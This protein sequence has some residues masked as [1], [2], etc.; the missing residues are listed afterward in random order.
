MVA[1]PTPRCCVLTRNELQHSEQRLYGQNFKSV[2]PL[3]IEGHQL[4]WRLEQ[5][6]C[7]SP[8]AGLAKGAR[9]IRNSQKDA[10]Q[11]VGNPGALCR[12]EPGSPASSP[13]KDMKRISVS[14]RHQLVRLSTPCDQDHIREVPQFIS[15]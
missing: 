5:K 8:E 1:L 4:F 13:P 9:I 3:V 2:A 14:I 11:L 12:R 10:L 6:Q 7:R 15:R